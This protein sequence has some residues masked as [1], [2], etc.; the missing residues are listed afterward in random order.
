MVSRVERGH[1]N[2]GS[3]VNVQYKTVQFSVTEGVLP[4]YCRKNCLNM[5]TEC[6]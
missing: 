6:P 4:A 5:F 3:N 2:L 1:S